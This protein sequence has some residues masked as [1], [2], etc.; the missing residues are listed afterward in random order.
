MCIIFFSGVPGAHTETTSSVLITF[1]RDRK[2]QKEG[3]VAGSK[4]E[5]LSSESSSV[6][7]KV[8]Q[9]I[10]K[11]TR[12]PSSHVQMTLCKAG[13]VAWDIYVASFCGVMHEV[14]G[15]R[16]VPPC[17]P[18][19]VLWVED[20][21]PCDHAPVG[22]AWVDIS[23]RCLSWYEQRSGQAASAKSSS[24]TRARKGLGRVLSPDHCKRKCWCVCAQLPMRHPP[25]WSKSLP[26]SPVV[27]IQLCHTQGDREHPF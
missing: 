17:P 18:S 7:L 4:W 20:N 14:L 22:S 12:F 8:T 24:P 15:D 3:H 11:N 1:P 2:G 27:A 23:R 10:S 16:P 25:T 13:V 5:S 19:P 21:V 26:V 9:P 6:L